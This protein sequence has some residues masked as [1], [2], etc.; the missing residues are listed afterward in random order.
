MIVP[1]SCMTPPPPPPCTQEVK[2]TVE[3]F[4]ADL[5]TSPALTNCRAALGTTTVDE[6]HGNCLFDGCNAGTDQDA[7]AKCDAIENM[8]NLCQPLLA[9]FVVWREATGCSKLD[10]IL[11]TC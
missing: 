6:L 7:V 2:L 10:Y 4:C 3:Q 1:C 11:K 5:K 8:V 9:D